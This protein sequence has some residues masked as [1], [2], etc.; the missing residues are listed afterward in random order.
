MGSWTSPTPIDESTRSN[1]KS[2]VV[3]HRIQQRFDLLHLK[4]R[5]FRTLYVQG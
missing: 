5:F 3:A 1:E 2:A 4:P